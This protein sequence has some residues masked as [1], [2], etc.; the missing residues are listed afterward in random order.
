MKLRSAGVSVITEVDGEYH[1]SPGGGISTAGGSFTSVTKLQ[2]FT[3]WYRQAEAI[4][5]DTVTEWIASLQLPAD[6]LPALLTFHMLKLENDRITAEDRDDQL[7]ST[8]RYNPDGTGFQD[9]SI[10]NMGHGT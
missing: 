7:R 6:E 9:Y 10:G 3:H 2:H 5:K 1:F 4:L 8:L